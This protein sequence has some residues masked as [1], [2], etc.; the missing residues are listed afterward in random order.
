MNSKN[1]EI[2]RLIVDNQRLYAW[3]WFYVNSETNLQYSRYPRVSKEIMDRDTKEVKIINKIPYQEFSKRF[4]EDKD[5]A[6]K[7]NL[8]I[9]KNQLRID[10][11]KKQE[12]EKTK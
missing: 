7:I 6:F 8:L 12:N 4:K 5:K 9:R 2:D 1:R 10:E 3:Y 11:L